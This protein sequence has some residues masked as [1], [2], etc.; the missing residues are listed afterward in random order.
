MHYFETAREIGNIIWL[1]KHARRPVVA[2]RTIKTKMGLYAIYETRHEI[3][4]NV[5]CATSKGSYQPTHT[6]S[7]IRAFDNRLDIL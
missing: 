1:A 6:R 5:V 4:K 2:K 7:L 3:S